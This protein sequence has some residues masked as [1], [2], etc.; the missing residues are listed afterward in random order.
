MSTS[1]EP[2][3]KNVKF[4]YPVECQ[5]MAIDGTWQK[6][7]KLV[8]VS[9]KAGVLTVDTSVAGLSMKEFFLVL[10]SVGRAYRR[11]ELAWVNGEKLGVNFRREGSKRALR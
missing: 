7:S 9:D 10:S 8:E 11:C 2:P 5:I 6:S 3:K 1:R 4:E